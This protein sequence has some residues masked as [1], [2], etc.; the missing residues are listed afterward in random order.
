MTAIEQPQCPK[1]ILKNIFGYNSFREGQEETINSILEGFSSL[2][3][4]PTGAGKSLCYQIPAI[5]LTGKT[6]IVVSPLLSLIRDQLQQLDKLNIPATTLNSSQSKEEREEAIK[7]L[8]SNQITL[9]FIS[10]ESLLKKEYQP[11]LKK[12]NIGIAAV[13]EAHCVSEWGNSFRPSYL[14][15]SAAIRKLKPLAILALTATATKD[16]ARDIRSNFKIK[17]KNQFQTSFFRENL[18]YKVIPCQSEQRNFILRELVA[19]A[20]NLP[21]IIYVMKQ[22]DAESVCGFL[23]SKG[24]NARSYHAGMHSD[25]RKL[26]QDDFINNKVDI[27]VATIAFGMGVNKADIRSVIH[28]HLPKS[29]EGWVQ[30]SGRAGRDGEPANCFLLACG[31]DLIPLTNFIQGNFISKNAITRI[32]ECIFSQGKNIAISKYNL[33]QQNDSLDAQLDSILSKLIMDGYLVPAGQSW[34]YIQ[35]SRLSYTIHDYSKPKLALAKLIFDQSGRIDTNQSEEIFKISA[36]K[37]LSFIKEMEELGDVTTK[38]SGLMHHFTLKKELAD[39]PEMID[40]LVTKFQANQ[41]SE[42]SRLEAVIVA[43]TTRS[44]I[45]IKLIK[46]FGDNLKHQCGFC[47]SCIGEKRARRLPSRPIPIPTLE[48]I[49]LIKDAYENHKT[50]LSTASRLARFCCGINSPAIWHSRLYKKEEYGALNHLP[51]SEIFNA[52]KAVVSG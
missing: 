28:Y 52:C 15:A 18:H 40:Q 11:I 35:V 16:V 2:S 9:L 8:E 32:I 4:F 24:V 13:D 47:S 37:L 17:T 20:A 25:A 39:Q 38:N 46:Y 1:D 10:P 42:I 6:S 19:E 3:I 22:I 33:C 14:L 48:D 27:V 49:Q 45:P 43:A 23:Q 21:A 5:A 26:V 44:C 12:L 51:F 30:E 36:V 29:P 7:Q 31:D 50:Q 34:R 41:T